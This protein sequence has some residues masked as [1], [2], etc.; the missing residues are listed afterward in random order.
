[1]RSTRKRIREIG[2]AHLVGHGAQQI[3]LVGEQLPDALR[4]LIQ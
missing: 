1:M 4:Q 3:S 2:A